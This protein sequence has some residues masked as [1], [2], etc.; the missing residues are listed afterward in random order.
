MDPL[1]QFNELRPALF[2]L[3]YRILGQR[4]DAEDVVQEAFLR[5]QAAPIGEIHSPKSYLM[6]VAGRLSLDALKAAYRKREQYVGPWLPEPL[7]DHPAPDTVERAQSL[8][9]AFLHLLETLSPAERVAFLLHDVFDAGYRAVADVLESNQANCRQLVA[10]A[11]QHLRENRPR[12][13]V[14][15][16]RH[17]AILRRFLLSCSTGDLENLTSMLK[18]DVVLYSDGG[19]R[20][21]AA[22]NPVYGADRVV[23]FLFGVAKKAPPYLSAARLADVN[24]EPGVVFAF[25]G[26]TAAVVTIDIAEDGKV[27]GIFWVVNPEK[28]A[29]AEIDI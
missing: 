18:E 5:W 6:T 1:D 28:L 23:K 15:R 17:E 14:D 12:Y 25:N 29:Q 8:S 9:L 4:A 11:R 20:A 3:A 19:G 22:L 24:G 27:R 10:R 13:P 2:S 16:A 26:V 7:V 21:R